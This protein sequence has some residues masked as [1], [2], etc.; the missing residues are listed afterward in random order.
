MFEVDGKTIL[1]GVRERH[2]GLHKQIFGLINNNL[3][4]DKFI[5]ADVCGP[6]QKSFGGHWKYVLCKDNFTQFRI[7]Y[8]IKEKSEVNEKFEMAIK[9]CAQVGYRSFLIR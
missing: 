9:D 4:E 6:F 7:I 5:H 2:N 1:K 8:C 3:V